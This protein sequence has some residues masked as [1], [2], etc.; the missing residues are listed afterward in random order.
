MKY[1]YDVAVAYRIYPGVSKEP[2]IF[3]TNKLRLAELCLRSFKDSL[4]PMRARVF[5]ILDSCPIEYENLVNSIFG[6]EHVTVIRETHAGNAATFM[7][8][9]QVL[10]DQ[11][12]SDVIFFA[13]DD[14]FYLPGKFAEMVRFVRAQPQTDF[15]TPF[16]HLDCYTLKLHRHPVQLRVSDTS[17]WRTCSST[18]LTFLTTKRVLEKTRKVFESYFKGNH[19]VSIFLSLTK[20]QLWNPI[21]LLWIC[22]QLTKKDPQWLK[23]YVKSWTYGWKQILFGRVYK[24]WSPIPSIATHLQFDTTSPTIDWHEQIAQYMETKGLEIDKGYR[25]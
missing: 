2:I 20:R 9:I 24:L 6:C 5:A 21:L 1:T 4:S 19:D 23:Y 12:D 16:D 25:I 3:S 22:G 14:Y 7:R 18:C 11:E 17:H 15:V 10:L 8:Q 13:E